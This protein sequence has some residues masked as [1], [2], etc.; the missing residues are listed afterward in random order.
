MSNAFMET[1][2]GKHVPIGPKISHSDIDMLDVWT[3]LGRM[4]RFLGHTRRPYTVLEHSL[5]VAEILQ[6]RGEDPAVVMAGLLHDAKEAY[7]GD[8]PTPIKK[9]LG[10][11]FAARLEDLER[12]IDSAICKHVGIPVELITCE[13]V[14]QADIDALWLEARHLVKSGGEGWRYS[15]EPQYADVAWDGSVSVSEAKLRRFA[16][17]IFCALSLKINGSPVRI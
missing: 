11:A 4:N 3:A 8:I 10:P 16:V 13:A 15:R 17:D 7:V 12:H 6:M 5:L 9:A 14:K 2:T 1:F